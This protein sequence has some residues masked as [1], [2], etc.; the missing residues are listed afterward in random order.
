MSLRHGARKTQTENQRRSNMLIVRAKISALALVPLALLAFTAA[1][2]GGKSKAKDIS[3]EPQRQGSELSAVD[4]K[5]NDFQPELSSDGTKVIFISGRDSV[6]GSPTFKVYKSDWAVDA[7]PAAPTRLTSEDLGVEQDASLSPDGAWVA[8]IAVKAGKTDLY[9]K[10]YAGTQAAVRIPDDAVQKAS[11]SFSPDGK[12]LTWIS[13]GGDAATAKLVTVGTGTEAD[14]AAPVDVTASTDL[15]QA[16][17]W[18]ADVTGYGLVTGMRASGKG[19]IAYSVRHFAT[20]A[21]AAAAALTALKSDVIAPKSIYGV[22]TESKALIGSK[23]MSY[24][25][26]KVDRIGDIEVTAEAPAPQITL[27]SEALVV[28]LV[29][30]TATALATTPGFQLLS[31]SPGTDVGVVTSRYY[32]GC[33]D[34]SDRQFGGGIL[35]APLDGSA[36]TLFVPRLKDVVSETELTF[37][38]AVGFCDKLKTPG[39]LV[40]GKYRLDDRVLGAAVNRS[41]TASKFRVAYVSQFSQHFDADCNLKSGDQ[42]VM[43]FEVDGDTR[44]ISLLS[45]NHATLTDTKHDPVCTL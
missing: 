27:D 39:D 45:A 4:V 19:A 18:T 13:R 20:I 24:E 22:A 7:K 35:V 9:I 11:P 38:A 40:G 15:A 3:T 31:M 21:D 23:V 30:G 2:C 25:G 16:V 44:T 26:R 17:F 6:A 12:L 10:D 42:E 1:G 33:K 8:I 37:E 41:A 43:A 14:V 28:D 5:F 34:E 32:Y 36:S 29:G